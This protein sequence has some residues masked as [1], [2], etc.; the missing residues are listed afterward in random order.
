MLC[1]RY[2]VS[3]CELLHSPHVAMLV[4]RHVMSLFVLIIP[5]RG[6]PHIGL[7]R[8]DSLVGV[9]SFVYR[10][11]HILRSRWFWSNKEAT[12]HSFTGRYIY[13]CHF[14]FWSN[15]EAIHITVYARIGRESFN[16]CSE[17][18]RRWFCKPLRFAIFVKVTRIFCKPVRSANSVKVT[19]INL[20]KIGVIGRYQNV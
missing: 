17:V 14:G 16:P 18:H 15:K 12:H 7:W 11:L 3:V 1:I 4:C 10:T 5:D 9:E 2:Y 8:G 13:C 6:L 19:R 20:S